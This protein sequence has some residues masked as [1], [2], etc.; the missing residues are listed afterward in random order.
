MHMPTCPIGRADLCQKCDSVSIDLKQVMHF[1]YTRLSRE[2]PQPSAYKQES[3]YARS[4]GIKRPQGVAC[5]IGAY[6]YKY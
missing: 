1:S 5:D 3:D 2:P 6:E 4:R